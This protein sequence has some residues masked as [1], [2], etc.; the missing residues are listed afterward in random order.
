[1]VHF[2]HDGFT[3]AERD[4]ILAEQADAWFA[5]NRL[6]RDEWKALFNGR[7]ATRLAR[8]ETVLLAGYR[9]YAAVK[10]EH[11]A[12]ELDGLHHQGLEIYSCANCLEAAMVH[13]PVETGGK[14]DVIHAECRVC[15]Y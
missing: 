9:F 2:Y 11:I 5:L 14:H 4:A 3:S 12:D 8:N 7:L 1:M 10:Y 15:S 13:R 6:L